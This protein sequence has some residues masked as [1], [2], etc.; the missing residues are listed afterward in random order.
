[1]RVS[2][3]SLLLKE[4]AAPTVLIRNSFEA[5]V[6]Y[7]RFGDLDFLEGNRVIEFMEDSIGSVTISSTIDHSS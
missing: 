5:K 1:M 7:I 3:L 6:S 2:E 4:V